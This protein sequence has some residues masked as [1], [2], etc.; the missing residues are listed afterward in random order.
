MV[1]QRRVERSIKSDMRPLCNVFL[2]VLFGC[3]FVSMQEEESSR[4]ASQRAG[5]PGEP[6]SGAQASSAAQVPS[7]TATEDAGEV[8]A[9]EG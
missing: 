8:P 9:A 1:E 4:K 5:G 3:L 2:T 6:V 7:A